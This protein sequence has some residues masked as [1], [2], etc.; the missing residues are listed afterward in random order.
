LGHLAAVAEVLD[1][2]TVE[3]LAPTDVLLPEGKM[4]SEPDRAWTGTARSIFLATAELT[5][6]DEKPWLDR[7]PVGW[8]LV[9]DIADALEAVVL[10][11]Q[12]LAGAG[13]L[14]GVTPHDAATRLLIPANVSRVA[15]LARSDPAADV[16]TTGLGTTDLSSAVRLVR[17]WPDFA[18]AQRNLA[19]MLRP[20]KQDFEVR[21][22]F[23]RPGLRAARALSHGQ[24]LMCLIASTQAREQGHPDFA[25]SLHGKIAL[26]R[27]LHASTTRLVDAVPDR[28][29]LVL[30]QQAEM[31]TGLRVLRPEKLTT[32]QWSELD[33]ATR[34]VSLHLGR[35]LRREGLSGRRLLTLVERGRGLPVPAP[36]S[37]SRHPFHQA[38]SALV[39][40]ARRKPEEG[41]PAVVR[42]QRESLR[43][44][45]DQARLP[46]QGGLGSVPS[47]SL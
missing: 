17:R 15:R 25:A 28:S 31:A 13:I 46:L 5:R 3:R 19:S 47:R 37:S 11:D 45:L 40:A 2:V 7:T 12:E 43:R 6:A 26:F 32:A 34:L 21:P 41:A 30:I 44:V 36:I 33:E 18:P 1:G 29:N 4:M 8:P 20:W 10:I 14:P 27:D 35:A 9:R 22:V 24:A 42:A 23:D 38:C 16:A 39:E